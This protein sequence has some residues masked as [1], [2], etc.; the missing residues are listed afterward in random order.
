MR[1]GG[2][3]LLATWLLVGCSDDD[4][5]TPAKHTPDSGT[6]ED[7]GPD[8]EADA[9]L[10][11][12]IV[13]AASDAALFTPGEKVLLSSDN[14]DALDEDP[15]V[16]A[17][18]DGSLLIAYFSHRNGNPDLYVR[19]T[20][21][22]VDW[23]E[24]RITTSTA[25][26]YYPNLSQDEAGRFHLTWFRWTA[27]QVGSVWY[28]STLDP[29]SWDE[30]NEEQITNTPDVDDWIPTL[31]RSKSGDLVVT[32]ASEKRMPSQSSELFLSRKIAG[33]SD[34]QPPDQL[35]TLGSTTEDDTLPAVTRIGDDLELVWVRC[36][37]G[38][39][40]PCLS[41][42]ADLFH[43][44]SA[45]EGLSWSAPEPITTDAPDTTADTLPSLY[46]DLSGS[47]ALLWIHAPP[48]SAGET[49]E[50]PFSD[51]AAT[52]VQRPIFE[53]Y[54][55]H[56]AATTTPGVF[57]AAWVEADATDQNK[58]DVYYRFFSK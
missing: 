34:W 19:R 23:T 14:P 57:L 44:T 16:V 30:A 43:S 56:A 26:D 42:S 52:P 11:D 2:V 51:L 3:V 29:M 39:A 48:A 50:I 24:A 6:L 10:V 55:P 9:E 40:A 12:V 15:C 33:S 37:P 5:V 8:T 31:A 28:S 13:D 41:A 32:F 4:S 25:A 53:G 7:S 22:G 47:W 1:R 45:D 35:A 21:N 58:K 46:R 20:T 27:F 54:S 49:F 38:G 17:A 36:A 18:A